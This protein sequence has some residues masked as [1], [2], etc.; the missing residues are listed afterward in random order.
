[1]EL[2]WER[3]T[4]WRHITAKTGAK[5]IP[6][7]LGKH[8]TPS[9]VSVDEQDEVCVGETARERLSL[10]PDTVAEV[11]KRSMG[12]GRKYKLGGKTFTPEELSAFVL[13]SLK[14]DAEAFLGEP[15]TEA[16]ISVPAYFDDNEERRRNGQENWPDLR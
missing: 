13:R 12:T 7:R 10:Y 2:T 4:A 1:M 9:V 8:L 11:F 5:I 15:V 16:V 6:N 3:P 14:E